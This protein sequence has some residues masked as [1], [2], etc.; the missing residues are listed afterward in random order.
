[1][2]CHLAL[3]QLQH[4]YCELILV[5]KITTVFYSSA[6][7]TSR[8]MDLGVGIERR[9]SGYGGKVLWVGVGYVLGCFF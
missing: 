2:D 8:E 1:M 6:C 3:V 5:I 4:R 7:R 9:R